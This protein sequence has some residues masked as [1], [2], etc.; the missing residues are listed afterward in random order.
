[1]LRPILAALVAASLAGI[2]TPALAQ[3]HDTP[4]PP[5]QKWSFA[6]PFGHFD[7]GQVQRGF[8]VYREVC[9]VCHGITLLSFRN[10]SDPGALGYSEAQIKQLAS[11]YE[12]QDPPDPSGET[13]KPRCASSSRST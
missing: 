6:G 13:P 8:K 4:Q 1:M 9:S 3:D 5:R 11:E 2:A 7:R 10:L 12:Y